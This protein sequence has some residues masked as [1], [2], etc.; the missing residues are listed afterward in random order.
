MSLIPASY[1]ANKWRAALAR[2]DTGTLTFIA[3]DG[4][5]TKVTGAKPGRTSPPQITVFDS[6]GLAIQDVAVA[7]ALYERA[8]QRGVGQAIELVPAR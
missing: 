4:E 5:V 6:T 1:I 3:P 7:A 2:I 8:L